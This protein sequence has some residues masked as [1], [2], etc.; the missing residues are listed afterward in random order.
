LDDSHDACV[1]L[2][3]CQWTRYR[4]PPS[5]RRCAR[6]R[7]GWRSAVVSAPFDD[8]ALDALA[9][10]AVSRRELSSCRLCRF[11]SNA[12]TAAALTAFDGSHL[13]SDPARLT[14]YSTRPDCRRLPS[15]RSAAVAPG[16]G[17]LPASAGRD[18]DGLS[19]PNDAWYMTAGLATST[20]RG[21]RARGEFA[22]LASF[23]DMTRGARLASSLRHQLRHALVKIIPQ[24][25]KF[26]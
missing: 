23:P 20:R 7:R 21:Y 10:F 2:M 24:R 11:A 19:F 8:D 15:T 6:M 13:E 12:A 22:P 16:P 3:P 14:R 18:G 17:P 26:N 4:W 5:K 9:C 1:T 25:D